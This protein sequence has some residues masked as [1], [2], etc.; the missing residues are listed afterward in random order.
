ML[1]L[2]VEGLTQPPLKNAAFRF[3]LGLMAALSLGALPLLGKSTIGVYLALQLVWSLLLWL[4]ATRAAGPQSARRKRATAKEAR[5]TCADVGRFFAAGVVCE[6]LALDFISQMC[7]LYCTSVVLRAVV[8]PILYAV[9][10][11]AAGPKLAQTISGYDPETLLEAIGWRSEAESGRGPAWKQHGQS[12]AAQEKRG[13][14]ATS[15][16]SSLAPVHDAGGEKNNNDRCKVLDE[17]PHFG[18]TARGCL[19]TFEE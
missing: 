12:S 4:R 6:H 18:R 10:L 5:L 16:K 15:R 7:L 11:L 8:P 14:S 1:N 9:L 19:L 17:G 13:T 3:S 2:L